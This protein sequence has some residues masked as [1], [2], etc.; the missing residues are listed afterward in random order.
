MPLSAGELGVRS[1]GGGARGLRGSLLLELFP[2]ARWEVKGRGLS[3]GT[4]GSLSGCSLSSLSVFL[5]LGGKSA[6]SA[7]GEFS[8]S[9]RKDNAEKYPL[10]KKKKNLGYC[11]RDRSSVPPGAAV[12]PHV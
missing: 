4:A 2:S 10:K 8:S 11:S 1:A 9:D 12:P 7:A 3:V 5:F 6:A